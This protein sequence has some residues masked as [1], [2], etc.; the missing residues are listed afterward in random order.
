MRRHSPLIRG[1]PAGG[2]TSSTGICPLAAAGGKPPQRRPARPHQFG[3]TA[4]GGNARP[5]RRVT[6]RSR[7]NG[8][9]PAGYAVHPSVACTPRE[10][11]TCRICLSPKL[12]A[13]RP[14]FTRHPRGA[15]TPPP[16][17]PSWLALVA[18]GAE[19]DT[20]WCVAHKRAELVATLVSDQH[21]RRR[22]MRKI[23]LFNHKG[24]VS[25]TTT[26]F[27]LGWMLAEHGHRV[28]M[29]DSDPQCNLTGMV[30]GFR[31]AEELE[32]FYE[33]QGQ[34]TLRSGLMPAFE[35][36]PRSIEAVDPVSVTGREGLFLL[37]G[38]LRLAEYEVTLGIAQELSAAIQALQ[39]LPGSLAFLV[40][41]TA[42][43]VGADYVLIDMSPGL[44]AVNQNLVSIS[45]YIIVPTAPDFFSVMAIDSLSRVLPRW[46]A[47]AEQ[48]SKMPVLQEAAY[49]FPQPRL[50]VLGTIVQKFRP[51][52]GKPA[53]SF[54]RWIDEL[55]N[56]VETILIPQLSKAGMVLDPS[57]YNEAG[58]GDALNLATIADF[59]SLIS[60]SQEHL[61]PVYALSPQQ[62]G[63]VGV[64]LKG[65]ESSRDAFHDQFNELARR[66]DC[67]A[68]TAERTQPDA[69]T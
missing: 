63:A 9:A 24:G 20:A 1:V 54:Q 45:D 32:S 43:S 21:R 27:N 11:R 3:T 14:G 42:E 65:F 41:R 59:N 49:P 50:R 64:V 52:A 48:A 38:D 18:V 60:M 57:V 13:Q 19:I 55:G 8:G 44:G 5:W 39:N 30:L 36:Q 40:D 34:N 23:A 31:G 15:S 37:A 66:V 53:S 58:V 33:R 62:M 56:A 61:T 47:W 22:T 26:V 29:V 2:G 12:S 6:I 35:A 10:A 28:L 25:K 4:A 67:L 16:M 7:P 17:L 51:R 46:R 69:G 68:T